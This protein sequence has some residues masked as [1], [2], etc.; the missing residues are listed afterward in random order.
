[1]VHDIKLQMTRWQDLLFADTS[2][3]ATMIALRDFR[4]F[5]SASYVGRTDPM[6]LSMVLSLGAVR[7]DGYNMLH[8]VSMIKSLFTRQYRVLTPSAVIEEKGPKPYCTNH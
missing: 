1:M 8:N 7:G 6:A 3:G 4:L 2:Y 5:D